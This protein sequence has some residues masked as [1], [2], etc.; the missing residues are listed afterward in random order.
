VIRGRGS[1]RTLIGVELLGVYDADNGLRGEVA[2]VVGHLL[3]RRECAL[4]DITHSPVRR[5]PVW[6][7]MVADLGVTF[8]LRHRNELT[9]AER[10]VVARVGAPVVMVVEH[11][12][13]EVLLDAAALR[14]ADGDVVRFRAML[15]E[16]LSA[17]S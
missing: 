7:A 17:R 16:A 12:S 8:G 3:G 9:P 13:L 5:K 14:R 2:Y 10:S 15:E 4:C 11:D 1:E 6:D